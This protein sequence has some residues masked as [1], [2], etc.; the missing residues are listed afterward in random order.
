MSSKSNPLFGNNPLFSPAIIKRLT[1]NSSILPEQMGSTLSA[2]N[3]SSTSSFRYDTSTS[4]LKST[5]QLSIDF[6][7]FENH[8]FFNSAESKTN[9]AFDKIIN[10]F[11]FD[12]DRKEYEKFF[13]GLSGFEKYVYD[14]FPTHRGFL[15]MSGTALG[16]D[17]ARGYPADL[18]SYI[19]VKDAA[20]ALLPSLSKLETGEVVI[21]PSRTQSLSFEMHLFIPKIPNDS[22]VIIQKRD[23]SGS[24]LTIGLH[25]EPGSTTC[26]LFMSVASGSTNVMSA[27]MPVSKGNFN[28]ICA[29][30]DRSSGQH[31]IKLY[32]SGILQATSQFS[33]DFSDF[34]FE[35]SDLLIGS[36][37]KVKSGSDTGAFFSPKQTFS[38]AIDELRIW[39][40]PRTRDNQVNFQLKN[41]FADPSLK[42]YYKFNEP[43]GSYS[44]NNLVLDS[45]GNSLHAS[46]TNFASSMREFCDAEIAIRNEQ[47]NRNP[48]LFPGQERV[49]NLNQELLYTASQYDVNNPNI[50]TKLVPPHY[51]L[52]AQYF[53]GYEK[54]TGN[55]GQDYATG[56]IN[57]PG[58]GQIGSPQIVSIMLLM[59]SS[60][61]D[62]LKM[63]TDHFSKLT[64]VKYDEQDSVS[65]QF[66]GFLGDYYGFPL[67][68]FY[69]NAQIKQFNEGEDL[70]VDASFTKH[71][72]R[73]IQNQMWRRILVNFRSITKS[74]G[75]LHSVK[76][77]VRACGIDPDN[78]FRFREF[79][80]SK[81]RRIDDS[82]ILKSKIMRF[83][84]FSGSLAP[85]IPTEPSDLDEAGFNPRK[86]IFM[87]TF[88]SGARVETGFP[89]ISGTM[90]KKSH[91]WHSGAST[92][93]HGI[94]DEPNDGLFTSGSWTVEAL[95]N[96]RT[97]LSSSLKHFAS[98]SLMRL[99]LSGGA[100]IGGGSPPSLAN[101]KGQYAILNCLA[102]SGSV[103]LNT[104]SSLEL[105]IRPG[106]NYIS[107]PFDLPRKLILT[108]V[109]IFD[110]Q[111]WHVSFGR[112]TPASGPSR[113]GVQPSGTY[114]L[115]AGRQNMGEISSFYHTSAL[116]GECHSAPTG[117]FFTEIGGDET[118]ATDGL[119]LVVGSQS[120]QNGDRG[121][122]RLVGLNDLHHAPTF[123]R[124]TDFSGKIAKIRFW[125]KALSLDETRDHIKDPT[126]M[127]ISNPKVNWNFTHVPTGAFERLR[128][129]ISM[130][131]LITSSDINGS[132]T[133][134]DYTQNF[135]TGSMPG[136]PWK[137]QSGTDCENKK[138][139]FSLSGS[140]F[141]K[142]NENVIKSELLYY[143]MLDPKFD[144]RSAHNKVRVRSFIEASNIEDHRAQVAPVYEILK[145][146]E[147]LDD[148]RFLVEASLV[149]ALNE[150]IVSIFSTLDE[151][152][153]VL[154]NPEAMF[155][156]NYPDMRIL[157]DIYFNR[158]TSKIKVKEFFEFFKWFDD[159]LG[160]MIEQLLP[161]KT[162]FMGVQFTIESHMLERA[163]FKY[164]FDTSYLPQ[165]VR[166][167][168]EDSQSS[169][170]ELLGDLGY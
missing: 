34:T 87:S 32:T 163:K 122:N 24:G 30:L 81:T 71:S 134:F 90:I 126:S 140:G 53:E 92:F 45:S 137:K 22:Q 107:A 23:D 151:L 114:F 155:A 85:N 119:F 95:Y 44:N 109:N 131:Q 150:D 48:I 79:G 136:A 50:I 56:S 100:M 67:P 104:S 165:R 31:N 60:Y 148:T 86:P 82:R 57:F 58:G 6:S 152:D 154:G 161:K 10:H 132:I 19:K 26:S 138:L 162:R 157:R 146:E 160:I 27:S 40:S 164:G 25:P 36:G 46:I 41:V 116:L 13:D 62:E 74:K 94:S 118:G 5:Q 88:L 149:S 17:P 39:S 156:Q 43:S 103:D 42:L 33:I 2:S 159:T 139:L 70:L 133:L 113:T 129:D 143:S 38:G 147:P 47:K 73:Y 166:P 21:G 18:G 93:P 35:K 69:T 99:H 130:D 54:E 127:G 101:Q 169:L 105:H 63:F 91:Q 15:W 110:G 142:Q 170:E 65:N 98:Q 111:F 75:T 135:F 61:F 83:L 49:V 121:T 125:S 112:V 144:E 52:D 115:R 120:L 168:D 153:N 117:T 80:G 12:G 102:I 8:T 141:E 124:V 4:P 64:T 96:F 77:L 59:W 78:M 66:L 158:L 106:K 89:P 37:S 29:V 3:I 7:K 68:A 167:L 11:P 16:E 55:T 84:D 9:V 128:L 28:H 123:S 51:L 97:N 145:S 1:Y 76:S 72:L 20:G 108:G 14:R